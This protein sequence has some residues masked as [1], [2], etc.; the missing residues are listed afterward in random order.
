MTTDF[1]YAVN[2]SA[3][4]Y[5]P[6]IPKSPFALTIKLMYLYLQNLNVASADVTQSEVNRL[7]SGVQQIIQPWSGNLSEV[8]I[9]V[10]M[11]V[12]TELHGQWIVH[13][14]FDSFDGLTAPKW[15][16]ILVRPTPPQSD[17]QN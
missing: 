17:I 16:L 4:V 6:D 7:R 10:S 3:D 11:D 2:L 15:T 8:D 13:K 5:T 1:V 9:L 12:P 14:F